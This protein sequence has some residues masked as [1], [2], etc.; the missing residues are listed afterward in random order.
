M[1][2]VATAR[3]RREALHMGVTADVAEHKQEIKG[4][5]RSLDITGNGRVKSG[6]Q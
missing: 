4:G 3:S 1:G 5:V 6:N 2:A